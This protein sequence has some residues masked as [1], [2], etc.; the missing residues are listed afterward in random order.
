MATL[1]RV[2]SANALTNRLGGG[3]WTEL[4]EI[5]GCPA[6]RLRIRDAK[7]L[8]NWT[9]ECAAAFRSGDALGVVAACCEDLGR[10][11]SLVDYERWRAD[12]LDTGEVVPAAATLCRHLGRGSWLAVHAHALHQGLPCRREA[13]D[14]AP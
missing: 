5:A 2:P 6:T 9:V 13:Q 12:K 1:D 3:R 14:A 7:R 4:P 10:F 8:G 11:P